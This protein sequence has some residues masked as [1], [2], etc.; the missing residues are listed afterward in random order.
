MVRMK[1]NKCE[2]LK[3]QLTGSVPPRPKR[4]KRVGGGSWRL[5]AHSADQ[6]L[7]LDRLLA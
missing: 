4:T 3:I 7:R 6:Q 2:F 1:T 5:R